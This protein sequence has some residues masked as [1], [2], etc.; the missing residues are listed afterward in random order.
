MEFAHLHIHNEYSFLDGLGKAKDYCEQA[1]KLGF[2]Q[3]A[4]TNHGNVDGCIKWQEACKEKGLKSILG[5]EMYIVPNMAV[6]EK[7]E[8]RH[9]ITLLAKNMEGWRN[10]LQML[11]YANIDGFYY[12][13]RI[14]PD[15][16]L[17][18]LDGLFVLTGCMSSFVHMDGGI[19]LLCNLIE[20]TDDIALE[21]M[22]HNIAGQPEHNRFCLGLRETYRLPIVATNDCHYVKRGDA[23][24]HE[25]LLAMQTKKSWND[26]DR[27][28]FDTDTLHLTTAKEMQELFRV[29]GVLKPAQVKEALSNAGKIADQCNLFIEK[30]EVKLPKPSVPKYKGVDE[31]TQLIELTLDGYYDRKTKH[32]WVTDDNEDEYLIRIDEELDIILGLGFA[33]YFLVVWELISWCKNNDIMCG[34]GRGSVGGSLVAFCLGITQVDPIKYDLVFSRFISEGRIDLPDIDM[35][36]E[37]IKRDQIMT[38]LRDLYGEYNV[39]GLSTFAQMHGRS[40]LRDVA[41]VFDVPHAEVNKAAKAIVVRSLGDARADFSIKDAFD[42]FE[43]G[44]AFYKKYKNVSD[45]AM[46]IEGQIKGYG[47]H[48]AAMCVSHTDLR[49][50]HNMNYALRKETL[51][52]NWDKD[53]AEYMGL[54]KLDVLG[55][56][57]LT[58][59]NQAKALIKK[60]HGVDIDYDTM[61]LDDPKVYEQFDKGHGVGIFQFNSP[62]MMRICREIGVEGFEQLIAL[63]ALHRPGPLRS[64]MVTTYRKRKHGEEEVTYVH[65]RIK[66]ITEK[67]QGIILY[68]EQVMQLMF[69]LGGLP[70][71][72]T[73]MIRKVISKRKGEEQF[74]KFKKLFIDGCTERKTVDAKSAEKI[75]EELQYFGS[76]GFNRAHAA[77]YA[78]IAA[79]E[80]WL[81]VY[82]P[83]EY[84]TTILTHGN[85]DKKAEHIQEARRLGLK[86]LLPDINESG[87]K[88]WLPDDKG[89]LLIPIVE[90]KG[91][92]EKAAEEIVKHRPY[93]N[94]EDLQKKTEKRK[95]NSRVQGL[96]KSTHCLDA[97]EGKLDMSE[98]ELDKLSSLFNF[99]LS[100]DPM[101]KY[102]KMAETIGKFVDIEPLSSVQ[103]GG[104]GKGTVKYHFGKMATLKFGYKEAQDGK[105]MRDVRGTAGDLGGVYG[106]FEDDTDF[107][108]LVFGS[109][110]YKAN[111]HA[112]EHCEGQWLLAR[113]QATI[114]DN[115][116]HTDQLWFA[117][118]LFA[119]NTEGLPMELAEPPEYDNNFADAIEKMIDCYDCELHG[120]CDKPVLPSPGEL[121]IMIVGEA[122]G[123]DEDRVGEGFVGAAGQLLWGGNRRIRGLTA[124]GLD[125]RNCHITNL[126]KCFPSSTKT[127]KKK[128]IKACSKWF[129]A[130]VETVKPYIMLVF[131]NTSMKYFKDRDSGITD[132]SGVTEWSDEYNCWICYSIHPAA[133][134]YHQENTEYLE[135]GL[136]NFMDKL[137]LLGF[138]GK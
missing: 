18:H 72:T 76:Y 75:F 81:K 56:N 41:R 55:L 10:L 63:N 68:Q 98:A 66:D 49:S 119:G 137:M 113:A 52:G 65:P 37:D 43:D 109:R 32:D 7:G 96:L 67:T 131:G 135:K 122:P 93:K 134:L 88:E 114:S 95:V 89:N 92:G 125:R 123:R 38:H 69:N 40:A 73:D 39:V 22:P 82:Y 94:L 57:A 83:V 124:R 3:I 26:K 128:H 130:E 51:V 116:I 101:Y 4:L 11:T 80:M 12:N 115:N 74:L 118:D 5:V 104:K 50:G 6:K 45:I 47:Q 27:W 107:S 24:M 108:M 105:S 133:V 64:G 16:L 29:Q 19:D 126:L 110:F 103:F 58:I 59:L 117:D 79:W 36:F 84:M 85:P 90:I 112:I 46:T 54:M 17:Q 28:R 35:D 1:A 136:S 70:W 61:T 100:N 48:A 129:K 31:D 78:M 138:S 25:V 121:N 102:R 14:D 97:P 77:E 34:P 8:K 111:K 87:A 42:S 106:N 91:I 127:P 20:R 53:D 15:L 120:E 44:K 60:R 23:K 33:R 86:L 13:P 132:M 21:L 62:G 9:H 2:K 71:K 30:I 99:S